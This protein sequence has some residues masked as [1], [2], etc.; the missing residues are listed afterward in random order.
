M[1][2]NAKLALSLLL[3]VPLQATV[4]WAQVTILGRLVAILGKLD[5]M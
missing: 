1:T 4:L 5:A 3:L 2:R